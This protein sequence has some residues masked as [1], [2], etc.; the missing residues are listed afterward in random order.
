MALGAGGRISETQP[1]F[2]KRSWMEGKFNHGL[3][4]Q[5]EGCL[6]MAVQRKIL[7]QRDDNV[8]A[9]TESLNK[10]NP[11][12]AATELGF[13]FAIPPLAKELRKLHEHIGQR[14]I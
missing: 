3:V 10:R 2:R 1:T 7:T 14:G 13:L 6:V 4:S 11:N 8:E 12:A 5:S 9:T